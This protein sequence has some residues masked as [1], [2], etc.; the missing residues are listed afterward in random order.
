MHITGGF[1]LM[2]F[3]ILEDVTFY[4]QAKKQQNKRNCIILII[5][6]FVDYN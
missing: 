3:G 6:Q 4:Y 1:F 5:I 2:V